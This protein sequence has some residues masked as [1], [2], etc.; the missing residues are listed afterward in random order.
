MKAAVLEDT[1]KIVLQDI[2]IHPCGD[3]EVLIKAEATGICRTDMKCYT[4]G[5]R[6]LKLP[7][8]LGHEI[9]GT[10]EKVGPRVQSNISAGD[11][12]Q[13]FPGISCG[14]CNYCRLGLDN[15]CRDI[16]IMGF[17][18][19]GGF[20]EYILIPA[21]GVKNGILNKIPDNLTFKEASMTEPLACCINIQEALKIQEEETVLILGGGRFGILNAK[22]AKSLGAGKTFLIEP[23]LSRLKTA[24]NYEFDHLINLKKDR[25]DL[26]FNEIM[27]LTKEKGVDNVITCTPDPEALDFGLKAAANKGKIGFFSGIIPG[28]DGKDNIYI[29]LIHYKELYMVGSYG[30]SLGH[31]KKALELFSSNEINV[32]DMITKTIS[33]ENLESGLN[34]VKNKEELSMVVDFNL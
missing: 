23:D 10:I 27:K 1:G 21:K 5:Q 25:Q 17:N 26:A 7:R 4:M 19:D 15:L 28:P 14:N 24:K 16:K 9:T 29:N 32:K 8:I 6:D 11:R 34:M 3:E 12:V 20:C 18:H 22:L 30:C 13:V 33:L 31:S 2:N